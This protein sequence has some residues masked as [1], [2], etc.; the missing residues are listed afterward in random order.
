M[1]SYP[2]LKL[3]EKYHPRSPAGEIPII[4]AMSLLTVSNLKHSYGTLIVLDG[5]TCAVDTGE[6]IGLV[7]R[8]GQGK[9]TLMKIIIGT[10]EPDSG[11]VQLQ[12]GTRVG[13]LSQHTD[14]DPADTLRDAAERAFSKLHDL[15][16]QAHEIYDAMVTAQGEELDRL[17]SKQ[18]KLDASIEVAGGYA[19][20][21]RIDAMLHG[22][23]F[24]D[25][26]FG[27]KVSV[28]S[29]GQKGRLALAKLLLEEPDLLLLDEPTNHL[30][31]AGCQWLEDFL[32]DEYPGTV[33]VVSHDRWLLDRVVDRIIEVERGVIREYPGNYHKYI[34]LRRERQ[35]TDSRV[36]EK[37]QDKVRQEKQFIRRYKTGQRA[38]QA[39]GRQS[40]LDRFIRDEMVERPIELDVMRLSLPD[41]PKSGELVAVAKNISKAYGQTKLFIDLELTIYRGDRIGIIGPNGV[42]KTTLIRTLLDEIKPDAG[43]VQL[44]SRLS[45]GYFQQS[46]DHLDLSL[47]VW[48]YLQNVIVGL[49]GQA[50]ASEQQARNLAG[51]FLF[52]G[53]D[54]DKTLQ[55]MSGGE[56]SR[57]ILAG[58]MAAAHNLLV[59]DEP[60]NHFDI[61]SMERVEQALSREGGYEGTILLISHD[62]ALLQAVCDKLLIFDGEG[63]VELFQGTLSDWMSRQHRRNT[64]PVP[65]KSLPTNRA[66]KKK[67]RSESH[68]EPEKTNAD[69]RRS[70][71][72]LKKIESEIETI[73][74]RIREIDDLMLDSKVYT[75]GARVRALQSERAKLKND[76][77]PLEFEWAARVDDA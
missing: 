62:R 24:S 36:Y 27:L 25:D 12:R 40:I 45:I 20:D 16:I 19:I 28:L 33:M 41:A 31:I 13:Y 52:S 55:D 37:Q 8:N 17:L 26:Q 66:V 7:G 44:G 70:K 22:L 67:A 57:A 61:P 53:M 39:R 6:K 38:K 29:G 4:F 47:E 48:R 51:A 15:H 5:A 14:L 75:D 59:L 76:I 21:H 3:E 68:H 11:T 73:E 56:R 65:A 34:D 32:A 58:L 18:A 54:Q 46:Q 77:E 10:L 69:V 9:T 23:G 50:K 60:T 43:S 1:Y 64:A 63:G 30:D 74:Q 72:S 2:D 49:D 42:G 71:I 35:L